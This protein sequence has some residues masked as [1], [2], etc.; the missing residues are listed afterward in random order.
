MQRSILLNVIINNLDNG[1]E[2]NFSKSVDEIKLG[3]VVST[4]EGPGQAGKM[5][6]RNIMKFSKGKCGGPCP[7]WNNPVRQ[8]RVGTACLESQEMPCRCWWIS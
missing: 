6:D 2:C 4:P 3:Q 1:M 5:A 7:G 8:Y